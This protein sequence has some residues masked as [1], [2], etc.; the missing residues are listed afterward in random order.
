MSYD[1]WLMSEPDALAGAPLLDPDR[2]FDDA[3]RARRSAQRTRSRKALL[4]SVGVAAVWVA[5]VTVAGHWGRVADRWV[6]AVT[7]VFGSIVAGSTP[8]GGGAIAFPV[9]TKVIEVPATVAR[10]FSLCIQTIGM[11]TAAIGD[12]RQRP[13]GRLALDPVC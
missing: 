3:S 9:F 5:F 1:P 7:M 12:R 13:Q 10:T 6:A 2:L 8:Q 4:L 11:G